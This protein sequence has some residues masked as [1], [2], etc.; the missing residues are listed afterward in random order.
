MPLPP[1]VQLLD[2]RPTSV[3]R[4]TPIAGSVNI[5]TD[6]LAG[7]MHELP[8]RR[9][10]VIIAGPE[11]WA[12]QAL[13]LLGHIGREAVIPNQRSHTRE[14]EGQ[15]EIRNRKSEI[16][17]GRLWKPNEFLMEAASRIPARSALDLACGTG[18]DAVALAGLGWKVTAIDHLA[19]ALDRGRDLAARYLP[20]EEADRIDWRCVDLE[21]R[22]SGLEPR[23]FDLVSIFWYLNRDLL[24][25]SADLLEPGG[26]LLVET[27]TSI[28]R[29]HFGKPKTEAFVLA[30]GEL[31][32]LVAPLEVVDYDEAWHGDRNS[33]RLWAKKS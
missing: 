28:H 22:G 20:S 21:A 13:D 26:S 25:K 27:F 2:P 9:S 7:R 24:R 12:T 23:R 33:A 6:E 32:E 30:P 3:A 11:P 15:S 18:R 16:E 17:K 29:E 31:R 14:V 5:P 8:S 1:L 10:Q 19:D 4:E